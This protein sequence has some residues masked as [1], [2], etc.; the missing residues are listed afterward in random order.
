[1]SLIFSHIVDTF[2][3]KRVEN[4]CV[5]IFADSG[6]SCKLLWKRCKYQKRSMVNIHKYFCLNCDPEIIKFAEIVLKAHKV[7]FSMD[8]YSDWESVD[9][10]T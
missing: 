1:M 6:L 4:L 7:E 9:S 10:K 3:C 8:K 2:C 5:S